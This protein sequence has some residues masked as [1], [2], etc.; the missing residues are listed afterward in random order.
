[1]GAYSFLLACQ[2][3]LKEGSYHPQPVRR[4]NIPKK[5]GKMRPLGI[6]TVRDRVIQMAS[7]LG[8]PQ[9]GVISPLL[10]NIYLNYFDKLWEKYRAGIGEL[11]RYADDFVIVCQT[12]KNAIRAF[13]IAQ[14][15]MKRLELTMHPTKTRLVEME[16]GEQGFDF[17]GM[18]HR[19]TQEKTFAGKIYYTTQQWLTK[20]A[21]QH[22]R[23]VVKERLAPPWARV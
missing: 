10:A 4:K 18:H 16:T 6:P 8:I 20:K 21:E 19:R 9:G 22:I 17:L 12:R 3:S 2:Q 11:T 5:D 15:I 23:D 7:K 14:A 13:G 1:M